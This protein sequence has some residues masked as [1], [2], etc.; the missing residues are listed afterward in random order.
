MHSRDTSPWADPAEAAIAEGTDPYSSCLFEHLARNALLRRLR[1][2]HRFLALVQVELHDLKNLSPHFQAQP[3]DVFAVA[4]LQR[5]ASAPA[6]HK[7]P[8]LGSAVTDAHRVVPCAEAKAGRQWGGATIF[9]YA[10]PEDALPLIDVS[11]ALSA[12]AVMRR[13]PAGGAPGPPSVLQ[14][15]VFKKSLLSDDCLG[16]TE[17]PLHSLNAHTTLDEWYPLKHVKHKRWGKVGAEGGAGG[18][19]G[20]GFTG[21]AGSSWFLNLRI[22]LRFVVMLVAEPP[23]EEGL[24]AEVAIAADLHHMRHS[25]SALMMGEGDSM[26]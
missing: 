20:A 1:L 15:A 25:A 19:W 14:L 21:G 7:H 3:M 11:G 12:P 23:E 16:G 22:T 26:F 8:T 5:G 2:P 4:R 17:V 9:R 13:H 6:S 18:T 24:D 10:L